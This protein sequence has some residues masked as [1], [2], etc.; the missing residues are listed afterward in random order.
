MAKFCFRQTRYVDGH[1]LL[2]QVSDEATWGFQVW[3]LDF[4]AL[5]LDQEGN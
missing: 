3:P 2:V 4:V 5:E 1:V